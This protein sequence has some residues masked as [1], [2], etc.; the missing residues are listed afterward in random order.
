MEFL[1]NHEDFKYFIQEVSKQIGLETFIIEKDYWVTYILKNLAQSEFANE[2]VFKGGTCL[3]KAYNLI[4]RFSEDVDLLILET[5]NT[6]SK[7]R[8]EKRLVAMREFVNSLDNLNYVNGN[9]SQL[10]AAFKYEFPSLTPAIGVVTKEI[11][12][13]PGYRGGIIPKI[14]KKF[15]T[16][17]VENA[18]LGKLEGYNI[19]SFEINV[20]ALE[21]IFMEKLFAL[22]EIYEKDDGKTLLTKTRHYYDIYKLLETKEI[23]ALLKN[24]NKINS[25]IEDINS[26][27]K[28]HFALKPV[29]WD[30]LKNHISIK[31]DKNLFEKLQKGFLNDKALYKT[32]PDFKEIIRKINELI[33]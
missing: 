24:Q 17:F 15:I 4:E 31:P 5:E 3:S 28:E 32:Q 11:L 18:L 29:T 7:T 27:G 9:R 21:R 10:Y 12:I 33:D 25:I 22:K 13:E 30:E 16:S 2:I 23:Q 14:K 26:V 20:L 1:H 19:E 6:K 8:K